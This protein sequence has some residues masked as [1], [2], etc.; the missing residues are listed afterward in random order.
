ME[1]F[2]NNSTTGAYNFPSH[3]VDPAIKLKKD[4]NVQYCQAIH[5]L[6]RNN[7]TGINYS[8]VDLFARY[9]AYGNGNQ[10]KLQYMDWLGITK[11]PTPTVPAGAV[12]TSSPVQQ[13]SDFVR[14]GYMNINWEIL[15]VAPNFKSVILGTFEDM[16]HDIYADGVDEKSSAQKEQ[17]KWMLW[18][19]KEL[20]DIIDY[21][22][23]AGITQQ[24]PDYVPDTLKELEMFASMGGFRLKS[25][26]S[27]EEA[28]RYT[29]YLSE[30]KEVKRKLFED[31]F[32][33]G[34]AVAKDYLDPMTQKIKIR[35]CDPALCVIP[36][37]H[38]SEFKNMP[39]AGEYIFYTI[40]EVRAMNKPD[41]TPQFTEEELVEIAQKSINHYN[42][43]AIINNWYI[44]QFGRY[45]YDTFRICVLDCEYKSDDLKYTTERVNSKGETV[46]HRDEFG[47]VRTGDKRKT[48]ISKTLMVY[49]CK[50]IVGTEY[51]WD[52]GHQFDIPRPTPSEANLSFHA[53]KMKS[54]SMVKRMI[55]LL[56]SIQLSWLKLQNAKAKAAPN[57]LAIEYGSLLNVSI[58]N[59]KLTPLE[60]LKIRN[61]TGDILY[62]ATTHRTY[63]PSQ[64]NYK[65]IQEL[66]GG[67]GNAGQEFL[68]LMSSDINM[69]RQII[70]ISSV[71]DA[72]SP[73]RDQS[74]GVSEMSLQATSTT[75]RPMYSAYITIKERSFRNAA[76]RIQ[77]LVKYNG[78]YELS[79]YKALGSSI[80]QTLKIGAEIN[81]A[82]FN[83]RIEA[84]P[85]QQEKQAL[86]QAALEAMRVGR[87]GVPLLSY[88]DYLIVQDF[89]NKGM[90]K[91]AQAYIAN[92][93]QIVTKQQEQQSQ[94]AIEQQ[95]QQ[96]QMLQQQ[97]GEQEQ[98]IMDAEM[99]KITHENEE[100]RKTLEM[101]HYFKMDEIRLTQGMQVDNQATMKAI[102][103]QH[104]HDLSEKQN[105]QQMM[106]QQQQAAIQQQQQMMQQQGQPQQPPQV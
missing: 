29:A 41:G 10:D 90:L 8:D 72:T 25:E 42:N 12:S 97:K 34:V 93:E 79:Y 17:D 5:T 3:S 103:M 20:S 64:T 55:P 65:P 7:L 91:M 71:A 66:Q 85:D 68:M 50:W 58:G 43:P 21:M 2:N 44:D 89:V 49:K 23:A 63:M 11:R 27:I 105:E 18:A 101:Q 39:F 94:M 99:A 31:L 47:K 80:T 88:S 67:L 87:Q 53:Y 48:N 61:Q 40:A 46:V 75:L 38:Q 14:Q 59:N 83:V 32:E 96:N 1:N 26:I 102:D 106:Q 92:R 95:G 82:M 62:Q 19:N 73:M 6:Y 13:P 4:W 28:L 54:G 37:V 77:L 36:Y 35:Y 98:A 51:A 56:D 33:L 15:S 24:T 81:N 104:Q 70:G 100:K 57:G 52:Y 30:W 16:E 45:E 76:L 22:N 84:K 69:I 78:A 9:R 60:V 86:L 74:V